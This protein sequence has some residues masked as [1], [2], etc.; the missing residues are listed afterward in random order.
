MHPSELYLQCDVLKDINGYCSRSGSVKVDFTV[1]STNRAIT[2][3]ELE[4]SIQN[5]LANSCHLTEGGAS[6]TFQLN[7]NCGKL[8]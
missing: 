8:W 7:E 2:T 6:T 4:A 1:A 3:T 5:S